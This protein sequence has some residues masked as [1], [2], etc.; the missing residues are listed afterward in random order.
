MKQVIPGIDIRKL[1]PGTKL[2]VNTLHSVYYIE[3]LDYGGKCVV[4]GGRHIPIPL[5]AQYVGATQSIGGPIRPG[6]I[7]PFIG[8]E[9]I[10]TQK[11]ILNTSP[12]LKARVI[13]DEWDYFMDWEEEASSAWEE[14]N[15]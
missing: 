5:T 2:E 10:L 13:G 9:F 3:F 7:S 4:Y 12:V 11:K 8:M 1:K 14:E 15:L 6:W